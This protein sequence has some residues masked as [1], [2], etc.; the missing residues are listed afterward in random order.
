MCKWFILLRYGQRGLGPGSVTS[1]WI[2]LD[3][4]RIICIDTHYILCT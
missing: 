3:I 1:H 4:T 2:G